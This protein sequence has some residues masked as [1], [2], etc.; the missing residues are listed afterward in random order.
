M[1]R[2]FHAMK[3]LAAF[4]VVDENGTPAP[5][6]LIPDGEGVER[7]FRGPQDAMFAIDL[8]GHHRPVIRSFGKEMSIS[9]HITC[10]EFFPENAADVE[11]FGFGIIVDIFREQGAVAE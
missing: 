8:K 6:F 7:G 3:E 1:T 4:E 9:L 11:A 10:Q 2:G 5:V